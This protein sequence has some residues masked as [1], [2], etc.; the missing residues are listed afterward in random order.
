MKKAIKIISIT[1]LCI[2]A[3]SIIA[4]TAITVHAL[5]S[6]AYVSFDRSK[7]NSYNNTITILDQNGNKIEDCFYINGYKQI[8]LDSL[9]SYTPSAFVSIEDKRFY[10][11]RGI[12]YRRIAGAV[13][14]NIKHGGFSE[15]ASTISQQLIKNTHLDNQK[16]LQRKINEIVLAKRLERQFSK[17]QIL[18]M[19]LNTIYFGSNAYGIESAANVFFGKSAASLTLSES[20]MLAGLIKS[21]ANYSPIT[22]YDNCLARRNVVLGTMLSNGYITEEQ[23]QQAKE[24]RPTC[25]PDGQWAM[26]QNY[27]YGVIMQACKLLN[28]SQLQLLNSEITIHTYYNP[29][30]QAALKQSIKSDATTYTNGKQADMIAIVADNA[31]GGISAYCGRGRF[32]LYDKRQVGSTAKP[33]AVYAPAF[34]ENSI[35]QASLLLD[36]ATNFNGYKP[37]NYGDKY[38]GWMTVKDAVKYSSN[39]CAVKTLNTV[40]IQKSCK[41]LQKIGLDIADEQNLSMA[42]GNFNGGMNCAELLQSYQVLANQ[43][44]AVETS[45]IQSITNSKGTI[46]THNTSGKKIFNSTT[47]FLVSD[48]LKATATSGTAKKM[49]SLPFEVCAKTGTVG[50]DQGNSDAIVA[51]YTSQHTFAVWMGGRNTMSN[52]VTGGTAPCTI[53][54]NILSDIYTDQHP[55]DIKAPK[56]IVKKYIDNVML[57]QHKEV[58]L[59]NENIPSTEK[60][61]YYFSINNCPKNISQRL[62]ENKYT[63]DVRANDNTVTI[64]SQQGNKYRIEIVRTCQGESTTMQMVNGQLIDTNL[65]YGQTYTYLAKFYCDN[66]YMGQSKMYTVQIDK[67]DEQQIEENPTDTENK[68]NPQQPEQGDKEET[69]GI[70]DDFLDWFYFNKKGKN[71]RK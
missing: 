41:Y 66:I 43:G 1:M 13:L 26:E 2:V 17:K 67:K 56:G 68:E 9:N 25:I 21:P 48:I 65:Q 22:H 29:A 63:I 30:I 69:H 34:E 23:Y 46:Y 14:S 39:V 28:M 32:D 37:H 19:Y 8:A 53:A 71:G 31:T 55:D 20:A 5:T 40:G 15:G 16:T 4:A 70:L 12:D 59:A 61:E 33:F 11:H 24:E 6:D 36:E 49:S 38:Y 57:Q 7:L 51:G 27:T 45:F 35:T 58:M 64:T 62:L 10:N 3:A 60:A 18:E 42:L 54:S 44:V 47:A 50:N 52:N